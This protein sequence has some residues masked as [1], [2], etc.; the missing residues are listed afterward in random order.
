MEEELKANADHVYINR[1]R[2]YEEEREKD[3]EN[4][5]R[6]RIPSSD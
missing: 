3:R 4:R 5:D 6:R 2:K 1:G